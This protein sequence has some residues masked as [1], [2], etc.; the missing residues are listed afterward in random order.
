M[1]ATNGMVIDELDTGT[2]YTLEVRA[3]G[4]SRAGVGDLHGPEAS[5]TKMSTGADPDPP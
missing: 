5:I 3:L 4:A 1:T 2:E